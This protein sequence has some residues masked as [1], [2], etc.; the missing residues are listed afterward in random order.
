MGF[1][2]SFK[3]NSEDIE[4]INEKLSTKLLDSF[5]RDIET[6]LNPSIPEATPL[7]GR[8]SI[9]IHPETNTLVMRLRREYLQEM[10]AHKTPKE[11]YV[12]WTALFGEIP[13]EPPRT[14][15]HYGDKKFY[16]KDFN[17]VMRDT[18]SSFYVYKQAVA[19]AEEY[20]KKA[21]R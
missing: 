11:Q 13:M 19:L 9:D 2:F 5:R 12:L 4:R 15:E 21:V 14:M 3:I 6:R 18:K 8:V 20:A 16:P 1:K 17:A 10:L 7:E